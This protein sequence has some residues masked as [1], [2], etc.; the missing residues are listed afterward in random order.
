MQV[1][2]LIYQLGWLHENTFTNAWV[3]SQLNIINRDFTCDVVIREA[4]ERHTSTLQYRFITKMIQ[5]IKVQ[6][7]SYLAGLP[8][9]LDACCFIGL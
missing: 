3:Q 8:L 1:I 9:K 4:E 2:C 6:Y 7:D 5:G